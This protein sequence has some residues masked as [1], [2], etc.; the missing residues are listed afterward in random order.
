MKFAPCRVLQLTLTAPAGPVNLGSDITY[1]WQACNTGLRDASG[2]TLN[3]STQVYMIAPIPARTVLKS[4]QSFPAGTLY[5][6]DSLSTAPL[7][8][9][10]SATAPSPLS[11]TTRIAFPV[12]ATLT[13]GASS[14]AINM[15]VTVNTGIDASV[16][17]DEIGDVFGNNSIGSP[18]TDQS[19]DATSNNGDGNADFNEGYV[20]GAGH[21]VI[22][23]TTLLAVGSVLI[24]PSGAPAAVGPT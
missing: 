2:V 15:I 6:T 13:A 24:G 8:A 12:G 3:G 19:G 4:G 23:R 5:T 20:A 22:Q 16:P 10:W 7:S 18:I 9:T 11:N 14:S 21:G 1:G 17:I